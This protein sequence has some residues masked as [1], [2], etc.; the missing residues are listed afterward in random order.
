MDSLSFK[1]TTMYCERCERRFP[2]QRALEQHKNDSDDHNICD[3]CDKDFATCTGL[4]QH[5][6]QS[7]R[8]HYCQ[9]CDRHFSSDN[10]FLN[11][12]TSRHHFC[13]EHRRMFSTAEGLRQHYIQSGDHYYCA[14]CSTLLEDKDEFFEHGDEYHFVCRSCVRIFSSADGLANHNDCSHYYCRECDRFFQSAANL[15]SHM[16]SSAAHTIPSITCPG[17]GCEKSFVSLSA[18]ILHAESGACVSGI[19][20]DLVYALV[21]RVDRQH[22]ITNAAHTVA[23]PMGSLNIPEYLEY[24]VTEQSWNGDAYECFLCNRK[25]HA[26]DALDAHLKSLYHREAKYLCPNTECG[27]EYQ[28]LSAL[29]QHVERGNC[30]VGRNRQVQSIMNGMAGGIR[31]I[32]A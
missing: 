8:H 19:T 21:E 3:E 31:S 13:G 4:E 6:A 27:N 5:Y 28:V 20:Y 26:F 7:P 16:A 12:S 15:E 11:H 1:Q 17:R 18:F 14:L 9:T 24:W 2:H 29:C 30:G 23:D 32:A 22:T 10:G 25:F